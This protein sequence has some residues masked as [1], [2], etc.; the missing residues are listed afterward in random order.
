MILAERIL[1]NEALQDP[2]NERFFLLSDRHVGDIFHHLLSIPD[3][4]TLWTSFFVCG[5]VGF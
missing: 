4:I 1:I 5:I 3:L 2:L